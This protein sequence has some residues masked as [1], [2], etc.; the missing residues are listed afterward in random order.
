MNILLVLGTA[1]ADRRSEAVYTAL[2][3][4]LSTHEVSVTTVDVRDVLTAPATQRTQ[5]TADQSSPLLQW[6]EQVTAADRVVMVIP[7]YN[8]SFPG[9]WKLLVDALDRS[10]CVNTPV[11]L[12]TVSGGSFAGVR[13][14]EQVLPVL[15]T[16]GFVPA[17]AKLHV[18]NVAD[19]Y[20]A[21]GVSPEASARLQAFVEKLVS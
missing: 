9:E 3:G 17:P 11:Y 18:G 15:H 19:T 12:A 8:H 7:E 4:S 5:D 20:A 2:A 21:D 16:L 6:Q 10:A 13:V 14:A 1:R